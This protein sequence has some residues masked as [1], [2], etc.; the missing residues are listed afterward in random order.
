MEQQNVTPISD[1]PVP[2]MEKG[3]APNQ[4][5]LL[6][7]YLNDESDSDDNDSDEDSVTDNNI[8]SHVYGILLLII[9]SIILWFVL[10]I[11]NSLK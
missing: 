5:D 7:R 1:L 4:F 10:K 8:H 11:N 6:K 2:P 3:F 9:T